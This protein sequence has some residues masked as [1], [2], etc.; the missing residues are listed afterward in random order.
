MAV[1]PDGRD[2]GGGPLHRKWAALLHTGASRA[3]GRYRP[4][5]S[6]LQL[7]GYN[8]HAPY[9]DSTGSIGLAQW[10]LHAVLAIGNGSRTEW[11]NWSYFHQ[12]FDPLTQ[13]EAVTFG[14]YDPYCN[15]EPGFILKLPVWAK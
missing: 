11:R 5:T 15:P 14:L 6:L 4:V 13:D 8:L 1:R 10:T 2:R 3:L 7:N 9:V 12:H